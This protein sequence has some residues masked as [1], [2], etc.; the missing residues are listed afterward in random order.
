MGKTGSE[1]FAFYAL[2]KQR[3]D[4]SETTFMTDKVNDKHQSPESGRTHG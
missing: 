1:Q 3:G 2:S 4:F